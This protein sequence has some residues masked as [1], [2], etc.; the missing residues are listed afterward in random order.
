VRREFVTKLLTRKTPPKRAAIF[1]AT[2]LTRE[3][4]LIN[5]YHGGD[6]AAQLLGADGHTGLRKLVSDLAPTGD[7]RAQVITLGLVLGSLEARTPKD[8]WRGPGGYNEFVT[9]ADYLRFLTANGYELAEVE[10]V[11]VGERTADQAYDDTLQ[12]SQGDDEHE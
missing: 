1:V 11:I 10:R 5:E 12:S 8:S 6:L 3:P 9:S 2:C 4:A 7:G